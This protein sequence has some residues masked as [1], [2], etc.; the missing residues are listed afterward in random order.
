MTV[1]VKR[2]SEVV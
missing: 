2:L 1:Y